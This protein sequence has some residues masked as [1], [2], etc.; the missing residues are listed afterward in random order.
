[1]ATYEAV[2]GKHVL[3]TRYPIT[4]ASSIYPSKV[5]LLSTDPSTEL[6]VINAAN[7][8]I[9]I[10]LPHYPV[11]GMPSID[12]TVLH[13]SK[14]AGLG[15]DHDGDTVNVNGVLSDDANAECDKHLSSVASVVGVN[16]KLVAGLNTD[17]C[18][19]TFYNMSRIP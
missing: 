15:G 5:H 1:M 16:G 10:T 7:G 11:K 4:G 2:R 18:A 6:S 12:S 13:P 17:L 9:N 8:E 14:L 3:I 19:L